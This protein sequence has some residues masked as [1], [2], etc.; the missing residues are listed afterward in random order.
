M[1][2]LREGLL[3]QFQTITEVEDSSL[4]RKILLKN[5]WNLQISVDDYFQNHNHLLNV[6]TVQKDPSMEG[7]WILI[8]VL[9]IWT[10]CL[11]LSKIVFFV[12]SFFFVVF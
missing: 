3:E 9:R 2:E 7:S 10:G 12:F 8:D 5:R 1:S 6:N 4:S 11:F